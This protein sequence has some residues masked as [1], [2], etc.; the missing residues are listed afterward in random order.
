MILL[1][2]FM[3]GLFAGTVDAIAGGGGL[4]SLPV[5]LGIGV[6][7]HVAFG[8]NKLQGMTGTFVATHKYYRHGLICLKSVSLGL[9]SGLIGAISGAIALQVL[10]S[11]LLHKIIPYLLLIILLYTIFSPRLCD[12]DHKPRMS[13]SWFYVLFGFSLGFY[14][15][16]FGPGTGSF[17]VIA[18]TFFLGHNIIKSTAYAKVFNLNSSAVSLPAVMS[19]IDLHYVW[20]QGR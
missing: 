13:E 19:I 12:I 20:R 3:T 5:L 10:N 9:V 7:P 16:F 17:W 15:G 14:D 2:L 6:P 11:D 1:L 18:L 8:T 4:I